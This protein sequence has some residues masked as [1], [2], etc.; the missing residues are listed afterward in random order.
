MDDAGQLGT[1][2]A[3]LFLA[4]TSAA[5]QPGSDFMPD[6]SQSVFFLLRFHFRVASPHEFPTGG[7]GVP[8]AVE[9]QESLQMPN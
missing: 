4:A 3:Y 8:L 1:D 5:L 9:E 6:R 7:V 2:L